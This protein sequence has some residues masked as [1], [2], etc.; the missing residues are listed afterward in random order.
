M[1]LSVPR[2]DSALDLNKDSLRIRE[3]KTV[4]KS[5][6]FI[7]Y[8][9]VSA[10]YELDVF[11]TALWVCWRVCGWLRW[12]SGWWTVVQ[13]HLL[14][15]GP[16]SAG[17]GQSV[18]TATQTHR[19]HLHHHTTHLSCQIASERRSGQVM[20]V[21]VSKWPQCDGHKLP[22]LQRSAMSLFYW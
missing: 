3:H 8:K 21:I 22:A 15:T 11:R 19:A 10:V 20:E 1:S 5:I 13:R 6:L 18:H 2:G 7:Y 9:I 12:H 16:P 4:F 17:T 14:L